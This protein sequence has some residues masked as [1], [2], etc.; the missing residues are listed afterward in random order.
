MRALRLPYSAA[1]EMFRR[2]VFNVVV[3]NQDDHTKNISFLMGQDGV[4]QLSPAYDMGYA[5][6]PNGGW[7]ATHQMSVNGKFD[8]I[9]RHDLLA[10]ALQN[11]IKD[12]AV[13]IDEVCDKAS[14]W[15]ELAKECGVP[16]EMI[17]PI[18]SN[19]LLYL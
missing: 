1:K 14:L 18:V 13:I 10:F 9:T 6:N 11:N 16:I 17:A 19:M 4:W 2:I 12:A 5:Y 15:P 7:T 8:D 3:R